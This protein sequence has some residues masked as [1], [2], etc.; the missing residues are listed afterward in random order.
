MEQQPQ[1]RSIVEQYQSS[2]RCVLFICECLA[3]T[4]IVFLRRKFGE[5]FIGFRGLAAVGLMMAYTLFWPEDDP[6][7]LGWFLVAYLVMCVLLR[8]EVAQRRRRGETCHSFYSGYPV[9]M[10]IVPKWDE[11][12]VKGVAEPLVAFI[13]GCL[14]L[15]VSRPLGSFV[16]LAAFAL[17]VSVHMALHYE[18]TRLVEMND[19]L[20]EQQHLARRFR[21]W[22]GN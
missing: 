22:N 7:P 14:L 3:L 4:V 15:P 19:R 8:I 2:A 17:Y 12:K 20:I 10:R 11:A 9:L 13:A 1:E 18:R 16:M 21:A 6:S 5:R